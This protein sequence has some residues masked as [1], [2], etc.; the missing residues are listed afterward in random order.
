MIAEPR[1]DYEFEHIIGE[2]L[3]NRV[4]FETEYLILKA[5]SGKATIQINSEVHLFEAG[6]NFLLSDGSMLKFT[7][8]SDD[9]EMD[10]IH[11][12]SDFLNEVYPQL[13]N[14]IFDII[15]YSAP[16]LYGKEEARMSDLL[17]EQLHILHSKNRHTFQSKLAI[18]TTINYLYEIYE[19]TQNKTDSQT[20][21]ASTDRKT[22]LLNR[23]YELCLEN[24]TIHRNIEF[25]A[26]RLNITSRYL[27]KICQDTY[28]MTP[29]ESI[30]YVIIRKAKKMLLTTTMTLQQI[31]I[32]LNFPDQA[33]FGQYF[34]R[35]V[36]ITP[37]EFKNRY[38]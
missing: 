30:D 29:K 17:F 28:Q 10:V 4:F 24:Y 34:K 18:N 7:E 21:S 35:K 6:T 14:R 9:F 23:F 37:S 31:S 15:I 26:E 3:I 36:G 1:Y 19:L 11:Y 8:C 32:Y 16:D 33:S 25:Y 13:D 22:E 20:I 27:Y 38:K 12:S 2:N 5:T